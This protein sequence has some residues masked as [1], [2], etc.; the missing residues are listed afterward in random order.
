MQDLKKAQ[1]GII[2]GGLIMFLIVIDSQCYFQDEACLPDL[3]YV[4]T[5]PHVLSD[6]DLLLGGFANH[7]INKEWK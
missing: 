5:A 7:T 4:I 6:Q 3:G 1:V 2:L